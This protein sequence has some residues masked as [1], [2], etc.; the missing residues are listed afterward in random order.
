MTEL[1]NFKTSACK[2]VL[3]LS[4]TGYLRLR[5]VV[6]KTTTVIRLWLSDGGGSDKGCCGIDVS[7]VTAK[8]ATIIQCH[9]KDLKRK[10]WS[11]RWNVRQIVM[12]R[13]RAEWVVLSVDVYI[14]QFAFGVPWAGIQSQTRRELKVLRSSRKISAE[15]HFVGE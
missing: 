4:E 8:L 2:R 6:V 7:A 9:N 12:P 3:D 1:R 10:Q 13:L 11:K 5:E 15:E 14:W